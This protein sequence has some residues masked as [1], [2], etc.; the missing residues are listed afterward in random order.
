M[1]AAR[2]P[3]RRA[4]PGTLAPGLELAVEP[5]E[6]LGSERLQGYAADAGADLDP[7]G[8]AVVGHRG[9]LLAQPVE[10]LGEVLR[11]RDP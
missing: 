7:G 8:L 9:W 10:P 3:C 6:V 5:V 2:D 1:L 11:H 4:P